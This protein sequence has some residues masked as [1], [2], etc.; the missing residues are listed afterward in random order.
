MEAEDSTD[1]SFKAHM[2]EESPDLALQ[3]V[4]LKQTYKLFLFMS[5]FIVALALLLLI[6]SAPTPFYFL[7]VP[8]I[9][10]LLLLFTR[11]RKRQKQANWIRASISELHDGEPAQ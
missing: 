7:L 10:V 3:E 1:T 8:L 6:I 9:A 5:G 2:L 4:K 11:F